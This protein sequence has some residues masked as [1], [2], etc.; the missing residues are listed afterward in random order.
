[1]DTKYYSRGGKTDIRNR[2]WRSAAW[3]R[4]R[5][6]VLKRDNYTCQRCGKPG[7]SVHHIVAITDGGD[8]FDPDNCMTACKPCHGI[9][10]GYRSATTRGG[11]Q[12]FGSS[13]YP[14]LTQLRKN[15]KVGKPGG[16]RFLG[17]IGVKG[18]ENRT[19]SETN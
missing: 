19:K 11:S 16:N 9:L 5:K 10:D 13:K 15:A 8:P 7:N 3:R 12:N 4:T 17:A 18:D 2:I 6:I 1:M 14:P